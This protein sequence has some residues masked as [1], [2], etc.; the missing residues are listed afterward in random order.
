MEKLNVLVTGG[1]RGI[2]AGIVRELASAGHNV[3]YCSR[4]T[5]PG[6]ASLPEEDAPEDDNA[7]PAP[8]SSA[9]T[10]PLP[11]SGGRI[12]FHRCDIS[13]ESERRE[14]IRAFLEEFGT[15]DA[16]VNNAGVAPE[17]RCDLLEMTQE[18]F[19]RVMEINLK[20]PFFL[21][22]LAA[23]ALLENRTGKFRCIVNIGSVSARC[24]NI[25]RG[26]Y[27]L[28][29]A[30]VAMASK[31]WTARLAEEGIAVYEIRPGIIRSDM[32]RSVTAKYDRL[33]ADGLTLQKRWGLPSDVGRAVR[34]L[35]S[36]D[37]AYSTGQVLNVDGGML[38]E[39]F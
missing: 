34:M 38:I 5:S 9:N 31:L 12:L 25:E 4:S 6:K 37:L 23:K 30:G 21:T 26:E 32:T 7:V 15:L 17:K 13:S 10:P 20:G 3:M 19:D 22:Q 16:L 24:A 8:S 1:S 35:L 39:R 28:S 11:N 2:G 29:K 33:I 14:L 36:G 27:C 18:S